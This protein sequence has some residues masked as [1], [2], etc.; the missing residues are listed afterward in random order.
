MLPHRNSSRLA[1][2]ALAVLA[3][4][5]LAATDLNSTPAP[6]E[7]QDAPPAD[8]I[9]Q[10]ARE[11]AQVVKVKVS[12]HNA[13]SL[14]HR[15]INHYIG[16]VEQVYKGKALLHATI[17]YDA[18]TET[19]PQDS[20]A[21]VVFIESKCQKQSSGAEAAFVCVPIEQGILPWSPLL[22]N[23]LAQMLYKVI[24]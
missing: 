9:K 22:D 11:S 1:A 7:S 19:Q 23:A 13:E 4:T 16:Q 8:V 24:H 18:V 3:T 12:S 20:D 14:N 2:L 10:M 15:V 6:S 5:A 17:S 21:Q